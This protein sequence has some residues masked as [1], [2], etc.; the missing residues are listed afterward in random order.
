MK[1]VKAKQ[2]SLLLHILISAGLGILFFAVFWLFQL[3]VFR[4]IFV[5]TFLISPIFLIGGIFLR[6]RLFGKIF[7]EL[8]AFFLVV[9]FFLINSNTPRKNPLESIDKAKKL[10]SILDAKPVEMDN[11]NLLKPAYD[12]Y[13]N[14]STPSFFSRK[15]SAIL[16]FLRIRPKQE[17]SVPD[18]ITLLKKVLETTKDKNIPKTNFIFK[19]SLNENSKVIVFGDLQGAF[20]SLVRYCD[21]LRELG[22][23]DENFKLKSQTDFWAIT[24]DAVSRSPYQLETLS[25]IFRIWLNNPN[26]FIYLRGN[27]ESDDY[28]QEFNLKTE[29]MTRVAPFVKQFE[30]IPLLTEINDVFG[31]LPSA[32]YLQIP[33]KAKQPGFLRI[34]HYGG[35]RSPLLIKESE[36]KFAKF[37]A[38]A[39]EAGKLEANA[40]N[41][42]R[43]EDSSTNVLV[44][45]IVKSEKKRETYEDMDG[46]RLMNPENGVTSWT[47]MSCPTEV[48][49]KG[50]KFFYDAFIVISF[51]KNPEDA[52][53]T[54]YKQDVRTKKGFDS[55]EVSLF[56]GKG[57]ATAKDKGKDKQADEDGAEA[58]PKSTAPEKKESKAQTSDTKKVVTTNEVASSAKGDEENEES[59]E[60]TEEAV[61]P[62]AI[63]KK[64]RS[65]DSVAIPESKKAEESKHEEN[66]SSSAEKKA[67]SDSKKNS[68]E[69][70]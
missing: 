23:I 6:Q 55:R 12:K 1:S 33:S 38:T 49:Q 14:A 64:E 27:H 21:K 36:N 50:L 15:L 22:L 66:K 56:S 32:V 10:L 9:S 47:V 52:K 67:P 11:T 45:A 40:F 31:R 58:E 37:L 44:Q 8:G 26:Q 35:D 43:D 29:L 59:N 53:I 57:A 46:L 63:K 68:T 42:V 7:I 24:G 25:L 48:F 13:Y 51:G 41:A 60:A 17:W 19:G 28:W 20:G 39:A 65:E 62:I 18:F 5:L 16:E 4:E 54:L 30:K 34:S 61:E 2:P 70:E 3:F 69:E